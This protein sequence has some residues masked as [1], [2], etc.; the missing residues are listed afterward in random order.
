MVGRKECVGSGSHQPPVP[1]PARAALSGLPARQLPGPPAVT[2]PALPPGLCTR[3][4][5]GHVPSLHTAR[6]PQ[7]HFCK[8]PVLI[9]TVSHAT[10]TTSDT[11]LPCSCHGRCFFCVLITL[12]SIYVSGRL[13]APWL[14]TGEH[15]PPTGACRFCSSTPAH[16][17]L[18]RGTR[19]LAESA[20]GIILHQLSADG[21]RV[22]G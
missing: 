11:F 8:R 18:S 2:V 17:S 13:H 1:A 22:C 6:R 10:V 3:S 16:L 19:P 9:T 4:S 21:G 12:S 7:R 15:P 5:S 20:R 14:G